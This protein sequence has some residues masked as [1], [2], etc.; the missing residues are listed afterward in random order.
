MAD[1]R[2]PKVMELMNCTEGQARELR[3]IFDPQL[4]IKGKPLYRYFSYNKSVKKG[5]EKERI[6]LSDATPYAVLSIEILMAAAGSF[7]GDSIGY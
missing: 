3:D 1:D 5:K 4:S 6:R 2:L 7:H